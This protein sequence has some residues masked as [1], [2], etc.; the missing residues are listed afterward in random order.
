MEFT[1]LVEIDCLERSI[2]YNPR[3]K[4]EKEYN[5]YLSNKIFDL[6]VKALKDW[7]WFI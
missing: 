5:Q 1:I 4:E 7:L 6:K 3:T 2:I